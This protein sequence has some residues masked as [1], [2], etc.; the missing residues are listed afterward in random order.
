[1]SDPGGLHFAVF[2][3]TSFAVFVILLQAV[4]RHRTVRPT[5]ATLS[6]VSC[7]VVLAGMVFA[8]VAHSSGLPPLIYYGVPATMTVLL[9]PLVFRMRRWEAI[10]YLCA[11]SALPFAIHLAFS[12]VLGWKE[13]LPFW[14]VPSIR[15][16]LS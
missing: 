4:L 15:E 6:W 8:K 14:A 13:Y 10:A 9:P 7:V 12:L 2:V 1:M 3:L 16:L 5:L 11:S